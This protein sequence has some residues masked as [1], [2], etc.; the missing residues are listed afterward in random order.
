MSTKKRT[1]KPR[2]KAS[3]KKK[4]P[5]KELLRDLKE[6][7]AKHNWKGGAIGL[8]ASGSATNLVAAMGLTASTTSGLAPTAE[9]LNCQEPAKPTFVTI[10]HPDGTAESGFV[11]L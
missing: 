7:F 1:S 2:K 8:H 6:V 3:K 5:T 9:S 4:R 10:H 11:C